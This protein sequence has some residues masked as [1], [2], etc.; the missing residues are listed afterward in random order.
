MTAHP[1]PVVV[2]DPKWLKVVRQ[3]PCFFHPEGNCQDWT[4][5]GQGPSEVSHLRGRNDDGCVLPMSGACH[6]T[7][8]IS[9]HRGQETFCKVY[10]VTKEELIAAAESLYHAYLD[11]ETGP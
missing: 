6:R 3:M 9:W 8:D 10:G 2:K 4:T 5:I 1:K 7:A 11:A